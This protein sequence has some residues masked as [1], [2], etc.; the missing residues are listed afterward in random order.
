[1]VAEGHAF[2][3]DEEK[4]RELLQ[5]LCRAEAA[6][7]S[8]MADRM[9][10]IKGSTA[11]AEKMLARFKQDEARLQALV[12]TKIF[13]DVSLVCSL[14]DDTCQAA[15]CAHAC[16]ASPA[17]CA[18]ACPASPKYCFRRVLDTACWTVQ[19]AR[20]AGAV[21]QYKCREQRD[22]SERKAA[23][24]AQ[25]KKAKKAR[26]QQAKAAGLGW[27]SC[28]NEPFRSAHSSAESP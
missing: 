10:N 25:K 20:T 18:H 5:D 17:A 27:M 26:R 9:T 1:M 2:G 23:E 3:A 7:H 6:F 28:G 15:A 13:L 11:G 22:A 24:R 21:A 14:V 19:E 16:P 12:G 4:A 8:Y